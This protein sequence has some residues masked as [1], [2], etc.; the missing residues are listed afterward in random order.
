M[1]GF[2]ATGGHEK[3]RYPFAEPG[4]KSL[5]PAPGTMRE[6]A[7][8]VHWLAMPLPFSL[9]WI[10][11]W[12]LED[13][14]GWTLV[15]CGLALEETRQY[16]R[17]LID[18]PR[19]EGGLGG[20]P[21]HRVIVTH[22]HPDHIGL[23]GWLCRKFGCELW[24]TRLEYITCRML[25]ADTGRDAPEDGVAFFRAAGWDEASLAEYRARFGGF[26]RAVSRLPDSYRRISEGDVLT[27]HGRSWQIITG[28][29]HSPDH[30]CLYCA[31]LD[32]LISGDQILPRIS[33][34]VSVFPT[35]PFADPL[36]DWLQSCHK[37][38]NRL[39]ANILVA[40]AHNEPFYGIHI[41]LDALIR[42]HER[43]L[44]RL[45][46]KLAE[47]RRVVDLFGALFARTIGPEVLGMATGETL[48][49]LNCLRARGL[50]EKIR[51]SDGIDYWR[52][53][54]G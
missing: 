16:W 40:P 8:G 2:E 25:V 45:H 5:P 32:L 43:S 26:G 49:H 53:T 36:S 42:G 34:N 6:I 12:A 31:E 44:D 27:I 4:E 17:E 9:K 28:N 24:M 38:R 54:N 52:Q 48:A 23:A 3:I 35:E 30:A 39:P 18:R 47:P 37:L 41:R 46:S 21:V 33:S 19:A 20:G 10:N 15:D 13:H 11:L 14:D 7:P 1:D 22:M 50:V 51:D 29:G